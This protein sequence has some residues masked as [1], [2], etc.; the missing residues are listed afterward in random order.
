MAQF[1]LGVFILDVLRGRYAYPQLKV[2]MMEFAA[3]WRPSA[4]LIEDKASGQSL[5][6]DLR[7]SSTLP[8]TPV[9][10]DGDKVMRAHVIVPTWEA[11]RVYAPAHAPWLP[12]LL[13]ELF[14][15]PKAPHDDQVDALV[16]GV[17][18]LIGGPGTGILN[19]YRDELAK[20]GNGV[21][22][23]AT[24]QRQLAIITPLGGAT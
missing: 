11:H 16:Q 20:L 12:E 2:N 4:L 9:K 8:V 3:K 5:I 19:Y 10:V 14:A 23:T 6:Q 15:F 22:T 1:D 21:R 18:Y 7:Q 17:R 13:E 24:R